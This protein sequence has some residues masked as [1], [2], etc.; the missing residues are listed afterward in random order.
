MTRLLNLIRH[1]RDGIPVQ[2][3]LRR[4]L[5][6]DFPRLGIQ[7]Q[8]EMGLEAIEADRGARK[9]NWLP[10]AFWR[11]LRTR[12]GVR[13]H[14]AMGEPLCVSW[15]CWTISPAMRSSRAGRLAGM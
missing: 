1:E 3:F 10:S 5:G 2:R 13:V 7:V 6:R 9:R 4:G 8:Y 14:G 15:R 12:C 11:A